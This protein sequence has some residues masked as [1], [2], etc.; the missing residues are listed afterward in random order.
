MRS[1]RSR[2]DRGRPGASPDRVLRAAIASVFAVLLASGLGHACFGWDPVAHLAL[3]PACPFRALTGL[4]C[5]GCGMSRAFV[6]LSQ[7]RL[8]EAVAV[9]PVAPLLLAAMAWRLVAPRRRRPPVSASLPADLPAAAR[10]S[11]LY[12]SHRRDVH[13]DG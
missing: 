3:F 12:A 11:L 7:L 2:P 5:P 9:H 4:A 6:L 13:A 1:T 8:A 10:A